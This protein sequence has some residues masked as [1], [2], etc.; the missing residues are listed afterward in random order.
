M[1]DTRFLESGVINPEILRPLL[2]RRKPINHARVPFILCWSHKSGCTAALKWYL[3]H[4]G[5]LEDAL[6]LHDPNRRLKIHSY[7]NKVLKAQ[8]GYMDDLV[9]D[10]LAGKP[11]AGFMRCPYERAFSSYMIL[12][13]GSFL[14]MRNRGVINPG[15][16]TRQAVVNFVH[17]QGADFQL[18]VSFR[19]YLQ[20]LR[21]QDHSSLN[22]HHTPQSLPLHRLIPIDFYRLEDFDLAVSQLEEKFCLD[23]S[24]SERERFSSGHHRS[25]TEAPVGEAL[26]FLEQPPALDAFPLNKLP[27][28]S[29]QLL[30]GT[31]F[32]TLI[33]EIFAE[34]IATYDAIARLD[35]A[36]SG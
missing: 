25:K 22:P 34:D 21:E 14:E 33:R 36:D 19:D 8:P 17:G 28:I 35:S 10:I 23:Q 32:E 12:N 3:H 31:G 5:V 16:R 9:A 27:R 11:A 30:A 26:A 1:A 15:M 2:K 13:H 20:W 18:A 6:Q 4:A 7:E 29:R 24:W